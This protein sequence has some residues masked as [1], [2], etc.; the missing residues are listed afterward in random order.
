M[1]TELR[2]TAARV[3]LLREIDEHPDRIRRYPPIPGLHD[4]WD[5]WFGTDRG[6][7]KITAR[8]TE[9]V[10]AG[11]ICRLPLPTEGKQHH[12]YELTAEGRAVLANTKEK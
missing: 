11:L 6:D 2:P 12:R 9:L 1:T 3:A 5:C 8:V 10:D 4:G 7:L